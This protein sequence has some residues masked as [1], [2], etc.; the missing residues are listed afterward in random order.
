[1]LISYQTLSV[2]PE[3]RD[4]KPVKVESLDAFLAAEEKDLAAVLAKEEAWARENL[5]WYKPLPAALAFKATGNQKDLRQRFCYAIRI[6]PHAPFALYYMLLPGMDSGGMP[7]IA[8][9]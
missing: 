3:V 9:E 2:L 7:L 8:P 4:A 1:P 6:N 5:V